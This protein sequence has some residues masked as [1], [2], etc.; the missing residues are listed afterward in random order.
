MS[1]LTF[2]R[3]FADEWVA[4]WNAGDLDRIFEHYDDD[5]DFSSPVISE[6]G[7]DES[8]KLKGKVAMRPYWSAGLASQPPLRF[9][10]LEVFAGVDSV[11]IFY[12]SVGRNLVCET[13]F[14]NAAGK[15]VRAL[16]NYGR[17]AQRPWS[18]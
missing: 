13:F 10:V 18:L 3:K 1:D 7:F 4:A 8:G 12:R 2:A 6:R 16:A 17:S 9:E 5:F 11:S 14:F 15:V